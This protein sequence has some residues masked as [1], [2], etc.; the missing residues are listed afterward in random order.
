MRKMKKSGNQEIRKGGCGAL[1]IPDFLIS[2]LILVFLVLGF[3]P[4]AALALDDVDRLEMRAQAALYAKEYDLAIQLYSDAIKLSPKEGALYVNRAAAYA[5]KGD[6]EKQLA[7]YAEAIRVDPDDPSAYQMRGQFYSDKV[8][9]ALKSG[10]Q[11]DD[12]DTDKALA[13]YAQVIHIQLGGISDLKAAALYAAQQ[14]GKNYDNILVSACLEAASQADPKDAAIWFRRALYDELLLKP[15]KAL[16]DCNQALQLDPKN[17]DAA[18]LRAQM[19]A[20][21]KWESDSHPFNQGDKHAAA[22]EYD[23]A[24]DDLNFTLWL[25]RGSSAGAFNQSAGVENRAQRADIYLRAGKWKEAVADFTEAIRIGGGD[26]R[27]FDGRGRAYSLGSEYDKA[28]SDFIT[29]A[30]RWHKSEAA[31]YAGDSS[32]RTKDDIESENAIAAQY[33]IRAA[34]AY[35]RGGKYDKAIAILKHNIEIGPKDSNGWSIAALAWLYATCP[36]TKYRDGAEAVR[37]AKK[38]GDGDPY[39]DDILA[40]AYAEAGQWNDAVK[41]EKQAI[42]DDVEQDAN[43]VKREARAKQDIAAGKKDAKEPASPQDILKMAANII[44]ED[45]SETQEFNARLDLYLQ[46]KPFRGMKEFEV[47]D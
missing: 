17:A 8:A 20:G 25:G 31:E 45:K 42:Q 38:A 47:G 9:A 39:F 24:V 41:S 21:W 7:D 23:L 32:S 35:I 6:V 28:A 4:I 15:D 40:A 13:D 5:A 11:R 3:F 26:E 34:E 30:A 44:E 37:L 1:S 43:Q 16:A 29:A 2:R 14:A 22:G 46:K 36:D 27:T 18:A 33:F 19:D 12:E 10:T